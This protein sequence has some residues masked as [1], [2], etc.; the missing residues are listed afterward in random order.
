VKESTG[1]EI[2]KEDLG[3]PSVALASGVIHNVAEDD[4]AVL[5][6]IRRYLSYFPPSA[7]SYHRRSPTTKQASRVRRRAFG[8]RARGNRRV[9]DMRAVLDVVFD[10]RGWFEVQPKFGQAMICALAHLGGH[11]VAVVANQP[12]VLAGSNRCRRRR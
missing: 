3:G 12:K 11:P 9:Y 10:D 7:W 8:H 2:S 6:D 1:E 4:E 5:D